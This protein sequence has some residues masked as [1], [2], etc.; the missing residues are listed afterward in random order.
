MPW[1]VQVEPD[2]EVVTVT[3]AG[4]LSPDALGAA[5]QSVLESC[6]E[7]DSYRVLADCA[8]ME[9]GHSVLE[10]YGMVER[11]SELHLPRFREAVLRPRQ[12]G[13]EGLTQFWEDAGVNRNL[14]V[15]LFDDR[16]AALEWLVADE[17]S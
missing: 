5:F 8:A 17:P 9:G 10:L 1:S 3:F 4:R 7:L 6:A 13:A 15:R 2:R 11:L 12:S 16:D 14:Q